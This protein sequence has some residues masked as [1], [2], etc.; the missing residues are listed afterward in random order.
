M[1]LGASTQVS[2]PKGGVDIL[3]NHVGVEVHGGVLTGTEE[4]WDQMLAVDLKATGKSLDRVA[5]SAQSICAAAEQSGT[6]EEIHRSVV[7]MESSDRNKVIVD[8]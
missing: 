7:G 6:L 2:G 5:P 4:G 3:V 8:P 1:Q